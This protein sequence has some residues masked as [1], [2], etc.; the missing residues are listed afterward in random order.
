MKFK[1]EELQYMACEDGG[2]LEKVE[3]TISDTTRWSI[4]YDVI[5]KDTETGKY[6]SSYYSKGST[7]CQDESPYEYEDDEI[8]CTEVEQKEVLVIKKW[9]AV[10]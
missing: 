3:E 10:K 9:V 8:E 5:F 7:E 4:Y 2:R 1:K 6:Y